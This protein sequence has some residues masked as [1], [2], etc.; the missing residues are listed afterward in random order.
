MARSSCAEGTHE[1]LGT[2]LFSD[3]PNVGSTKLVTEEPIE[4]DETNNTCPNLAVIGVGVDTANMPRVP[5]ECDTVISD[6][7]PFK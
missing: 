3:N 1:T 2:S 6:C 4:A 7:S 5:Q